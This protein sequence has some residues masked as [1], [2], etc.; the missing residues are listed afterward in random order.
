M[1]GFSL[2]EELQGGGFVAFALAVGASDVEVGEELHFDFLEAVAG[3]AV[4]AAIAGVEGEEA[5][6]C[7][8]GLCFGG[9]GEELADGIEGS[10]EDGGRGARG[11]GDG[12][13]IDE[14]NAC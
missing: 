12:G 1:D 13:L 4:A 11:A 3:A 7:V 9:A 5:G 14:F 6:L 10:E 8:G 2:I